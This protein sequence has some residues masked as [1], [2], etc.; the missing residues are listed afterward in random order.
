MAHAPMALAPMAMAT[1]Q[2]KV[3]K[4]ASKV[5]S[6][7]LLKES[8]SLA[9]LCLPAAFDQPNIPE[10]WNQDMTHDQLGGD[11]KDNI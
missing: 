9:G 1:Q 10:Y 3:Q 7:S 2:A 6:L 11:T 4:P 5:L 8:L